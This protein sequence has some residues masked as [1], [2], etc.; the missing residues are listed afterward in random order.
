MPERNPIQTIDLQGFVQGLNRD[1][2][3]FLLE[4]DE[5]PDCLN[6]DFGLRG[7]VSKRAGYQRYDTA[8]AANVNEQLT[9]WTRLAGGTYLVVFRESNGGI[10]YSTGTSFTD[11]GLTFSAASTDRDYIISAAALNDVLYCSSLRTNG[12]RSFDGTTWTAMTGTDFDGTASRF[13]RARH[14]A[15]HSDRI[16]AANVRTQTSSTSYRSRLYWSD[17]LDA[18]TWSANSYIDFD[19]DDGEEITGM[20]PFGE[21]LV[22]FKNHSVQ[23]LAGR[24]EASFTRYKLDSQIGTYSPKT[25]QSVGGFL[26]FFDRDSGVHA[27][28]GSAF[29]EIG[30]KVDSYILDGMNYTEAHIAASFVRR[31]R[32]YLSVPW[33]SDT[34]NSRTF[35][36]DL[37]TQAWTEYDY[38][39]TDAARLSDGYV[40]VNNRNAVGVF[41]LFTGVNDASN[42]VN[43]HFKT[44]WLAPEGPDTK[45]RIRRLDTTWSAIGD[46]D[47][48]VEMYRDFSPDAYIAQVVNTNPGGALFGTAKFGQDKFGTAAEQVLSRTTGWG[49]RFRT[50]QF[51]VYV[52]GAAEDFQLNTMTM[53]VSTLGRV[54]GEA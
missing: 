16:F 54:R 34:Y 44:P 13:P 48:H 12:P 17:L 18:E 14:L 38:G 21:D 53:H 26:I 28:D 15:T 10:Y 32:Y 2:D 39:F 41:D 49:Q 20:L 37:R 9:V 8:G 23:I 4:L 35:V 11:S 19:P 5:V 31:N 24:S 40:S 7:E 29:A 51:K 50:C 52:D 22:V 30:E 1:A 6:V 3:P 47:V 42:V 36:Y 43:A 45:A 25:I 27:F 33:G 46:T